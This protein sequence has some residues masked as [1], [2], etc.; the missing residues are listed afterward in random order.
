M[1][2]MHI[3]AEP[4]DPRDPVLEF[5]WDPQTG[6]ISGPAAAWMRE[7]IRMALDC[8]EIAAHPL[9]WGIPVTDPLHSLTEM[10]AI[11]GSSTACRPSLLPT[12]RGCPRPSPPTSRSSTRWAASPAS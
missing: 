3:R 11:V 8:G 5:A 7:R 10:A 9:P 6:E 1:A 12:T 2:T 4:F